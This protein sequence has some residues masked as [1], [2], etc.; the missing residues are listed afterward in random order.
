MSA[1][2]RPSW[3]DPFGAFI[4]E[5][6]RLNGIL[7]SEGDRITRD[8]ELSSARWQVLGALELA[9]RPRSVS[10]IAREM[11]L[12]RQSVQRVVNELSDY[13]LL[14]FQDNPD[15]RRSKNVVLTT[16]GRKAFRAAMRRQ[17]QWA[18]TILKTAGVTERQLSQ[19]E[20]LCRELRQAIAEIHT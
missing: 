9:D 12:T 16:K 5:L 1:P 13:G 2:Q 10:Q 6:F 8:L 14:A 19:A 7:L 15:H 18:D 4:V 17:A 3:L 11:G 20:A